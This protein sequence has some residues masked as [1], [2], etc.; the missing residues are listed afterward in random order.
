MTENLWNLEAEKSLLGAILTDNSAFERVSDFLHAGHFAVAEH[1]IVFDACKRLIDNNQTADYVTLAQFFDNNKD[2]AGIGG[3]DYLAELMASAVTIINSG[4]YGK[5]IHDLYIKR[6]LVHIGQTTAEMAG[7]EADVQDVIDGLERELT[8]LTD[9]KGHEI[10]TPESQMDKTLADIE[11]KR[12]GTLPPGLPIGLADLDQMLGGLKDGK[13]YIP[14]GRPA[15][16]KSILAMN[17]AEKVA[18]VGAVQFFTLEMSFEEMNNRRISAD[19]G[20]DYK[21][22]EDGKD[23]TNDEMRRVIEAGSRLGKKPFFIDDTPGVSAEYIKRHARRT[24][25]KHGLRLVVVDYLQLMAGDRS[26]NREQEVSSITRNLK[27]LARELGCP[28]IAVSQLSRAVEAREGQR[29]RM[30]DLRESGAIEQDADVVMFIYR[31]EYY[32]ELAKPSQ[33]D[34]EL[35]ESFSKRVTA[36]AIRQD[37]SK[38]LAEAII[39]KNRGGPT[40]VVYLHFTGATMTFAN[41]ARTM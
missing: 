27:A 23:L 25:R 38:G 13:L 14:A 15:M 32:L 30:S 26:G 21:R 5:I 31:A 36:H 3:T 24:K 20:I 8:A 9:D 33:K 6:G 40:G 18:D 34:G 35:A 1:G 10:G 7:S 17:A 2:L 11:A 22:I 12:N 29:P 41:L 19:T 37:E 16:G 28:V 4:E 39:G